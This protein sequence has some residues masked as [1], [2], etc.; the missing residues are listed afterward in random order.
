MK[1]NADDRIIA[2]D[3]NYEFDLASAKEFPWMVSIEASFVKQYQC[4]PNTGF[5][6]SFNMV[7]NGVLVNKQ[8][9]LTSASGVVF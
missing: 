5:I 7:A 9:I 4:S 2:G 1:D 6:R 8:W 3:P